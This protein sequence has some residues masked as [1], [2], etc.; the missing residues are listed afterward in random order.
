MQRR[1]AK[2]RE[3][4]K[5]PALPQISQTSR[6]NL[7]GNNN[8][9]GSGSGSALQ[10]PQRGRNNLESSASTF[11]E[12]FMVLNQQVAHI[13]LSTLFN[14]QIDGVYY[15]SE[16]NGD[17]SPFDLFWKVTG[18]IMVN[19]SQ[20]M[21]FQTAAMAALDAVESRTAS[22]NSETGSQSTN[23]VKPGSKISKNGSQQYPPKIVETASRS[24][25]PKED[26]FEF[27]D[28]G[29]QILCSYFLDFIYTNLIN[30][31]H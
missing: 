21:S 30:T 9:G 8:E 18:E 12:S 7:K 25:L 24:R 19:L 31:M 5:D 20:P 4:G 16:N 27:D 15:Q 13:S 10:V 23:S 29:S 17:D 1:I 11:D 28:E 3:E 22:T 2:L 6:P 26:D 14:A